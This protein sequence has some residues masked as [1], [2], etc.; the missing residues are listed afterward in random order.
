[1]SSL[2]VMLTYND[3]TVKNA[4]EVFDS[5]KDIP[6]KFWGFKNIGLP[7]NQM[8][9]LVKDMKAAGKTTFLEVVTLSEA[10]CLDGAKMAKKCGFDYLLGTVFYPSVYAFCKENKIRF[11][12]FSG[13]VTGH[14]SVLGGTVKEIVDDAVRFEQMGCAG[15]DI[16]A[17]RH[18]QYPEEIIREMCKAVKFEVVV[19]GSIKDFKRIDVVEQINP[20]AFT[21]GTAL[22]DGKF[23]PDKSF[24][25]QLQYVVDHMKAYEN[26]RK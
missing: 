16:L 11:L 6:V 8:T 20:W 19:A 21:I 5:C 14:P 24:R 18:P 1:M 7:V 10:E 12:P 2:I 22:F 17:Y 9:E 3:E 23:G 25:A 4:K 26:A 13:K 15:T